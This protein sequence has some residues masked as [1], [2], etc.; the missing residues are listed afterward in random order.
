MFARWCPKH[1][2]SIMLVTKYV[3][4]YENFEK[5]HQQWRHKFSAPTPNTIME[6]MHY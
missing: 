4:I 5:C 2:V 1:G 3:K 6:V